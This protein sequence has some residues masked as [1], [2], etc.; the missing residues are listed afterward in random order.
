MSSPFCSEYRTHTCDELRLSHVGKIVKLSGWLRNRRDHGGVLFLELADHF[1]ITQIVV[2]PEHGA[3]SE[4]ARLNKETVLSIEGEVLGRTPKNINPKIPTG[5]IELRFI[6]HQILGPS[7]MTPFSVFPENPVPE[8]MRLAYRFLDLRRSRIHA[9]IELRSRIIA[10]MRK[11]MWE[12]G[13]TEFQTPTL[14]SSS[15]EGARDFLVPSRKY[16]GRFYA[17]PQAPQQFKQLLM[18][19]GFD[20]YFQIAPC[21]RDE[22][23]RADRSPGEFYQLDMEMSFVTQEEIFSVTEQLLA[24]LFAEFL[25]GA[26]ITEKPFPRIT[27]KEAMLRFGNDKPDLRNPLEIADLTDLFIDSPFRAFSNKIVRCIAAPSLSKKP[28]S[29]FARL[30]EQAKACGAVGLAWVLLDET[31]ASGPIAK[32]LSP[33]L[34]AEI[35]SRTSA[36][37][38]DGIFFLQTRKHPKFAIFYHFFEMN[39]DTNWIS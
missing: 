38:G 36:Q 24:G 10:S 12:L 29:F 32:C 8:D 5:E 31:S 16:P 11:R 34:L 30:E 25:P 1:G 2:D 18:A 27:Y 33:E 4:I 23:A 21:Y 26:K 35:R 17:L 19:S 14:T 6:S 28:R 3:F 15:P 20:R 37:A 13:F 9:N 22:D 39:W 7:E